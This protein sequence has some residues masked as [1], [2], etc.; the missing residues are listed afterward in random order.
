MIKLDDSGL[1]LSCGSFRVED[2]EKKIL[3][4]NLCQLSVIIPTINE[5]D[6]IVST[7]SEFPL[8][9]LEKMGFA[10]EVIVVD[11]GS[12]DRTKEK[13]EELRA[14]VIVEPRNGYGRAYKTG[15]SESKGNILVALDGDHSYPVAAIPTLLKI[16]IEEDLDFVT[17]S[18]LELMEAKA[19]SWMHRLGNWILSMA[20]RLLFGVRL[21]DSQSGMWVI[22]RDV[23][24][25]I[26]P[27][28]DGMAFSEEIKI[29]AF[30]CCKCAEIPIKY[31][32]RM[33]DS[34]IRTVLDGVRNLFYLSR[35][36]FSLNLRSLQ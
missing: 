6:G 29:R 19:M 11:G 3:D 22:K 13:A 32:R 23:L 4:G 20:V 2:E 1:R 35:L 31:R 12:S 14:K 27:K 18:R 17:A 8:G 9:A 36:R 25:R 10:C 5:E 28:S 34:K 26:L 7:L 16:M 24:D 15:F 21:R 33:G 30:K